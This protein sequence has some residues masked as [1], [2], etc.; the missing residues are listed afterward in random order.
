MRTIITVAIIGTSLF[1]GLKVLPKIR[2]SIKEE[3]EKRGK[4]K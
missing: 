4:I 3:K 1:I 2:E